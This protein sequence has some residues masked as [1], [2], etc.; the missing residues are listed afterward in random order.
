MKR[1]SEISRRARMALN[2]LR[3][4]TSPKPSSFSSLIVRLRASSVKISA[5]PRDRGER[6]GAAH[7]HVDCSD[8]RRCF[9]GRELVGNGP[10]RIARYESKSLLPIQPI[11]FVDHA[12]DVV[13]EGRAL[14]FHL[15]V[16]GKKLFDA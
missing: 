10:A 7:L 8:D 16:K 3:T 6:A 14:A 4:D 1:S 9:L 12:I 5:E 11:D 15:G 13:A 2:R